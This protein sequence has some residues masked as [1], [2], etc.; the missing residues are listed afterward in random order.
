MMRSIMALIVA[1]GLLAACSG[2]PEATVTP[3]TATP[4]VAT[5]TAADP[6]APPTEADP[7]E[8]PTP[9]PTPL[10]QTP[11]PVDPAITVGTLDN[12]LTYY[13]R[14]NDSPG[15]QAELRLVVNAGSAQEDDDQSG[16]AHFLEHMLFNGTEA[17][18]RNELIDVLES[19][20][21]EFG[22]EVNAFTSFDE[23]V[24]ELSVQSDPLVLA[25]G[26]TVL[27]EWAS[28]A[29][30]T[31][32]DVIEERGVVLDEWRVRA[33]G[34]SGREQ[35]ALL[36]FLLAGTGYEGRA[37][38]GTD[39]AILAMTAEPL[40]R[41]YEQWYRPDL[42]AVVVVGDV[43]A[44][45]VRALIETQFGDLAPPA[46]ALPRVEPE[47]PARP[48]LTATT[49]LDPE[50]PVASA[51]ISYLGP[52]TPATSVETYQR[53]LLVTLAFDA[54]NARFADDVTT[55]AAPFTGAGISGGGLVRGAGG[56]LIGIE[57]PADEVE[58]SLRA[59]FIE[60][61]RIRRDGFSA[62]EIE[63]V[64]TA[65][66]T[67][68]EQTVASA[69]T[70]QD[71][72]YADEIV[73]GFLTG[74]Q[75]LSVEDFERIETETLDGATPAEV[76]SAFLSAIEGRAPA[77]YQSG[78]E[79]TD[80]PSEAELVAAYAEVTGG[81][82][83]QRQDATTELTTLLEPP[84]AIGPAST[85][86][87]DAFDATVLEYPNGATVVIKQTDI[88]E[89]GVSLVASSPGGTSVLASE[90]VTAA[91]IGVEAAN[92][93]GLA[94][95]GRIELDRFLA[96]RAVSIGFG[97]DVTS[98][99]LV[100][101]AR[102]E[103]LATLFQLVHLA[104]RDPRVEPAA[105]ANVQ[106]QIGPILANPGQQPA[107]AT[108]QALIGLRYGDDA[109][110]SPIPDPAALDS[111]D[112]ERAEAVVEDRFGNAADFVFAIVGDV[113]VA[114]ATELANQYIATLPGDPDASE[115]V[116]DVDPGPPPGVASETVSVGQDAQ[117]ILNRLYTAPIT[118]DGTL[119]P[120]VDVLSVVVSS[121]LRD[122]IREDLAATYSP[123]VSI[124]ITEDPVS[125]IET[126][127][128]LT[129]DPDGLTEIAA[130][131]DEEVSDLA[132]NGPSGEELDQAVQ[133]VLRDYGLVSNGYW[134]DTLLYYLTH[135]DADP[136][137]ER[138]RAGVVR[139]L[140]PAA[141]A[142]LAG[143]VFPADRYI[144]VRTVP[145]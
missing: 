36:S 19:F 73:S 135:P 17:Y 104:M 9:T 54:I 93:S 127:V 122:R 41:F 82:I 139:A 25:T 140:T 100:G 27:R 66:R 12:G 99:Q 60:I 125:L 63:R 77:I 28:R 103:D 11:L 129:G 70:I 134:I 57:A 132:A 97:I 112:A 24:Y 51:L 26:L 143:E 74:S 96:D 33:Q 137:A 3:P 68:I 20:G 48:A 46:D 121:R 55:G 71:R 53:D 62:D 61:E 34:A 142:S 47:V 101:D 30:I 2:S 75:M 56:P 87:L 81:D 105:L 91:L 115:A 133:Q 4:D 72:A 22:P 102:T 116:P 106:A 37:P 79:G 14:E 16:V 38:I 49:L 67:A 86:S 44:E 10:P 58:A 123:D 5:D 128:T 83:D 95:Y 84:A 42:M 7:T 45:A 18:P 13:I 52:A 130:A 8:E 15:G 32:Q 29:T 126:L 141:L 59:V 31:E 69:G 65:R 78:P 6:T 124:E 114:T 23:T 120:R 131:L 92:R 108:A 1:S 21:S 88:A 110:F 119:R 136:A 40:R 144:E 39:D 85:T 80:L 50:I 94:T 43:D 107:L 64:L 138:G 89:D 35:E 109:R 145:A 117:G 118:V 111:T 98:E 113:D 76:Q 90:D